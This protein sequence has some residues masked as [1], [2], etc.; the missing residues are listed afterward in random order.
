[1]CTGF[2]QYY[3]QILSNSAFLS[4]GDL[5]VSIIVG[6]QDSEAGPLTPDIVGA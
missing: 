4:V 2:V 1:M 6:L 5:Y 3:T